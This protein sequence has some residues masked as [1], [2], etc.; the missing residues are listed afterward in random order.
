MVFFVVLAK[1][2]QRETAVEIAGRYRR[3]ALT[4]LCS[5]AMARGAGCTN[6]INI[7]VD[8]TEGRNDIGGGTESACRMHAN[9]KT[10]RAKRQVAQ[11][12]SG[13]DGLPEQQPTETHRPYW[14]PN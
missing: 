2:P 1:A 14:D 4:T 3:H 12:P 6:V 13:P 8:A 5:R 10:L 7:D 9:L 11:W